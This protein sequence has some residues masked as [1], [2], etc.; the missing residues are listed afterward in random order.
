MT[1][2][3][4]LVRRFGG[5]V[6]P[7]LAELPDRL[8]RLAADWGLEL[9]NTFPDGA[10]AVTLRAAR[11]GV[12]VV[13]KVSPDVGFAA[14]QARVLRAF[15]PSGRVPEL[16]ATADGAL[17]M[18]WV[19]GTEGWPDPVRFAE[20]LA[21]LHA[22]VAEPEPI[23][24]RDLRTGIAEFFPRFPPTGPVTAEHLDRARDLSDRLADSQRR[25]VL[26]HGDLHRFNLLDTPGGL[27][28]LDPQGTLGEPEFRRRRLRARRARCRNPA[29]RAGRR[30]RSRRRAA[31]RLVSGHGA[32][33]RGR[34]GPARRA[35]GRADRLQRV[36]VEVMAISASKLWDRRPGVRPENPTSYP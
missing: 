13:L 18:A 25:L 8:D 24:R 34:Q 15:A 36:D 9:G 12:P 21:D 10:S 27:V 1:V 4:R 30:E 11:D 20:L 7:W 31:G 19:D 23:A 28:A 2:E 5:S 22:A 14:V 35:G 3:E 29:R 33:C 17:L 32:P 6:R 26:L 16:L